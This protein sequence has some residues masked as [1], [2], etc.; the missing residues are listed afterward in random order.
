VIITIITGDATEEAAVAEQARI[1]SLFD[2]CSANTT[3]CGNSL[4]VAINDVSSEKMLVLIGFPAAPPPLP[5]LPPPPPP[6]PLPPDPVIIALGVLL[7]CCALLAAAIAAWALVARRWHRREVARLK[8]AA[9]PKSRTAAPPCCEWTLK[10]RALPSNP[11]RAARVIP[12]ES[13]E[14]K[15]RAQPRPNRALTPA[16]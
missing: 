13:C 14:R 2:E 11:A 4:S 9:R 1:A 15:P 12:L 6:P 7:G 8:A 5:P 3:A 16:G 10:V